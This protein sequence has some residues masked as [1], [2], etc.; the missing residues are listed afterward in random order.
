[1]LCQTF[2]CER[3]ALHAW[4]SGKWEDASC[5]RPMTRQIPMTIDATDLARV[6]SLD[7]TSSYFDLLIFPSSFIFCSSRIILSWNLLAI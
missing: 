5:D 2:L 1:M 3:I 7:G 6:S 4:L